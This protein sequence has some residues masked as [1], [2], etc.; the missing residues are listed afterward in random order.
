VSPWTAAPTALST[1]TNPELL[2][3]KPKQL[4]SCDITK[5]FGPQR[6]TYPVPY[7]ILILYSRYV[8]GWM[9][10]TRESAV[11]A[12]KLIAETLAKQGSRVTS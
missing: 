12:E 9:F 2:A 4:W 5:L 8:V 1:F 7:V 6:W 11:L 3:T 10:A